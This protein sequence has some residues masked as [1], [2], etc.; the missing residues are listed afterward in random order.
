M[1]IVQESVILPKVHHGIISGHTLIEVDALISL[2]FYNTL[3]TRSN[4]A[5]GLY[6]AAN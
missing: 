5:I 2:F 1:K 3:Q 6:Y 4:Y